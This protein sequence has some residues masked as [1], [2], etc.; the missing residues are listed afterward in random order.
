MRK[1]VLLLSACSIAQTSPGA[2]L[3]VGSR[4]AVRILASDTGQT[5]AL[6]MGSKELP[7]SGDGFRIVTNNRS[8]TGRDFRV[9]AVKASASKATVTLTNP[10]LDLTVEYFQVDS[11]AVRKVLRLR[12]KKEITLD[13][14]DVESLNITGASGEI[15]RSESERKGK[16]GYPIC[17]FIDAGGYGA[18]FSL[19]FAF[20]EITWSG[21]LLN[22]G[23]QPFVKLRAGEEYESHAVT[24]QAYRLSGTKQGSFDTAAAEAFRSYIRWDYAPPHLN[25]PQFFY[26][27]IVNRFTEVD[28]TVPPAKPSEKP[29][30]NTIFYTLSDANYY[31]LHPENIPAEIDFCKSLSMDVCQLY[32][33]P[34]EW[35]AGNPA[36][37]L[38]KRI[39]EYARDRGVK[40]GLYT[41]ANQLTAPHFNHYGQDKGRAEWKLL[42]EDGKRGAYCWGSREF[43][44][45]FTDILIE[46]SLNFNFHDANFDFLSIAPCFDPKHGHAIGEK[47]IYRQVYNL[48][49]SLDA[50]RA[51]VPGYVYDSNLGWP[52]FVPKIA[53]SMDAFYLT[54][55]HFTT[56]F[57]SLNATEQQDN[58]R[59]FQMVSYF[60][61]RLTPVEYFRNCEYFVIPDSV[62]PDSKIFEFG[63][64]QGL[65]LTPNL[66]LG[67]ARALFDR[68][69]PAQ[70]ENA[71]RFLARWTSFVRQ[72]FELYANTKILTGVPK[73]GQVE[74]YA[75]SAADRSIVFLVNPNPFPADASFGANEAIGLSSAGPF[76][77]HELYPEDRL[78]NLGVTRSENVSMKVPSRSVVVLEIGRGPG[79]S[80]AP[81]RI[82]GAPATYDRFNDRYRITLTGS[83]GESRTVGLY[84]PD[85]E[86]LTKV[87]ANGQALQANSVAGGY[88]LAVRFPKEKVE[89]QVQNWRVTLASLE[90]GIAKSLWRETTAGDSLRFPQVDSAAPVANFLGARIE[91]LLNERY[92]RELLV[93][94]D[95]GKVPEAMTQVVPPVRP[96]P[97]TNVP[98]AGKTWW[99]TARFPVSYVQSFIPPAPND[100]NYISLNFARPGEV[101]TIK[102]WLNGKEVPVETFQYWRGPV[103]AKNFY[104]DGTKHGLKRGENA[105]AL[106][107]QYG[108]LNP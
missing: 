77:L 69:S 104:I 19:D 99:Y 52:P 27:S 2:A 70:Q 8:Y 39:G 90:E 82:T 4:D 23:Y 81:L 96:P 16:D 32:E 42:S 50:V 62:I 34:F 71:R 93:Y 5:T 75:H 84:L 57:P 65:A 37:S 94:F 46:T 83:Q 100:H 45:W 18:F 49:A 91:N 87:E 9:V 15:A 48:V 61:N 12:S 47:G 20:S 105:L 40:L 1:F 63:V 29:I 35:I 106:F 80:R 64:L 92:S 33:G 11:G 88:S 53:R 28:K 98:M 30:Q 103:W 36:A 72:N 56:Y 14:V 66:Q 22:V 21:N 7:A 3:T 13:R 60:L 85:G 78:V 73:L 59:R 38:A 86:R 76:L 108:K 24:F 43:A 31:M 51:A 41:G 10:D 102:V 17:V 25:G 58:S 67:E 26:T 44:D 54:D 101:S 55:P 6:R 97:S 89:D 79:Y 74:I 68:F 95:S 107:V